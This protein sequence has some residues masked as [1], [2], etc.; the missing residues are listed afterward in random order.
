MEFIRNIIAKIFG[1]DT[2]YDIA[3]DLMQENKKLN[4]AV[5]TA[6][7]IGRQ[8]VLDEIKNATEEENEIEIKD[9]IELIGEESY[10]TN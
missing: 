9:L 2:Y 5:F 1:I 3:I 8:A 4:D 10:E 6:Y 7:K